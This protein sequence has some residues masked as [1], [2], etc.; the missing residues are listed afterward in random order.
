MLN[1]NDDGIKSEGSG[2]NFD[3]SK[4]FGFSVIEDN[5]IVKTLDG[6]LISG[7]DTGVSNSGSKFF[8]I[9]LTDSNGNESNMREYEPDSSRQDYAKKCKSQQ[10]RLKHILT[11]YVPEGTA[12]PAAATFPELWEAIKG[13][14]IANS[15]NTKPMRLKLV[16]NAKGFL[17]VPPY[18]PFLES[19]NVPAAETKLNLNP[20]FDT[21][22]RPQADAPAPAMADAAAAGDDDLPF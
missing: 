6:V 1:L 17:T 16:Y 2:G 20:G 12:L 13:L 7:F 5:Q 11:K 10:T 14:L 21:L 22:S 4:I 3:P 19:M 8:D 15:C 9:K 18:V